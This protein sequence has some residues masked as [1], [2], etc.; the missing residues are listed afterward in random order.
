M[1]TKLHRED[2]AKPPLQS[3]RSVLSK[4]DND[5]VLQ[6]ETGGQNANR[7]S[8]NTLWLTIVDRATAILCLQTAVSDTHAN[9]CFPFRMPCSQ[10]L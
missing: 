5:L 7:S 8:K 1:F 9:C 10:C 4:V 2:R 6:M 3:L